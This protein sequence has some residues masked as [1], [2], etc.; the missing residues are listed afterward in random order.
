MASSATQTSVDP[1]A[2]A[3]DQYF[4]SNPPPKELDQHV[5]L[6]R[7]FV[8]QHAASGRRVVLVTSGGTTGVYL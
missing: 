4:A 1:V 7:S 5:A 6:A 2:L 3:E 8:S